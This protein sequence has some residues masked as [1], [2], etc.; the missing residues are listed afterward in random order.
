MLK[1]KDMILL[2]FSKAFDKVNHQSLLRKINNYGI[3]NNTLL[4]F[5]DP[6][7]FWALALRR[8]TMLNHGEL[9]LHGSKT[10]LK[11]YF[12]NQVINVNWFTVANERNMRKGNN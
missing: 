5:S 12:I 9:K 8:F 10:L 7:V 2:D 11:A 4:Y 6:A 3:R 1:R